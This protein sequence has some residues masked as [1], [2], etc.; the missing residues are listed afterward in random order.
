M[1]EKNSRIVARVSGKEREII[2][3]KAKAAGLSMS[4]YIRQ[5]AL[6]YDP[7]PFSSDEYFILC[8]KIDNLIANPNSPQFKRDVIECLDIISFELSR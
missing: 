2:T 3:K 6:N 5:R 4:E 7:T 1:L 8:E